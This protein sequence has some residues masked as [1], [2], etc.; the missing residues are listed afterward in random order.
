MGYSIDGGESHRFIFISTLIK[1]Y[2][3]NKYRFLHVNHSSIKWLKKIK[4]ESKEKLNLSTF[5]FRFNI[6]ISIY[7]TIEISYYWVFKT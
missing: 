2:T 3:L 1:L 5:P 6:F 4:D 7:N